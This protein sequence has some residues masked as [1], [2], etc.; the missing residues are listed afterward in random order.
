MDNTDK[1]KLSE[2]DI[3]DLFITPAIKVDE[4]MILCDTLKERLNNAQATRIQLADA[5]VE[6]AVGCGS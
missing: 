6:Q 2:E 3:R 4:L 1:K 5:I